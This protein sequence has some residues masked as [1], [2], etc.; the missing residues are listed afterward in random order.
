MSS[1]YTI[2]RAAGPVRVE[3]AWDDPARATAE[4]MVVGSFWPKASD[5][6]PK[7]EFRLLWD[8]DA[9][10]GM[11]RV[12]DQY[13]RA[14]QT[15][16]NGSVCADSC[17]EF[18]VQPAG[19]AGYCNFEFNCC[20]VLLASHIEDETRLPGGFAQWR[21][22]TQEEGR[23]VAV[24]ASLT[25]PIPEERVGACVWTLAFRIP[26]APLLACTGAPQ[27]ERGAVWRAN[28]YKCGDRTSH[29][30]WGAWQPVDMLNF[31]LPR[32]FGELRFE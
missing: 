12:E 22:W 16:F 2:R 29:P 8:D 6:R 11:F 15:V 20:G 3:A 28:V 14:V 31:H 10:H 21:P 25:G 4:T 19:G 17:V 26:F 30:H 24:A 1:A 27:P 7:T 5:H 18:F 13:V 32:C 9:L 23:Q